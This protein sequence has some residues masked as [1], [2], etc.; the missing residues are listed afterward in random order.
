MDLAT[1][2]WTSLGWLISSVFI[3][4]AYKFGYD[5]AHKAGDR[6]DARR[7]WKYGAGAMV[8][9]FALA[10]FGTGQEASYT[11]RSLTATDWSRILGIL[12]AFLCAFSKGFV[13]GRRAK[14]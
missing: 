12:I 5:E 4:A 1:V 8:V 7:A 13:D 10:V 6:G 11:I 3:Y 9:F 14:A 2:I